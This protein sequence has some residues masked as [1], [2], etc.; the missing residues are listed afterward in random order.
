MCT[1]T[2]TLPV[3]H[4][5]FCDVQTYKVLLFYHYVDMTD[6]GRIAKWQNRLCQ[7]LNLKGK[8][9][10]ATEGIN[11]TAEGCVCST[12]LYMI[13]MLKYF[14]SMKKEDFKMSDGDGNSFDELKISECE[15]L[16][17]IGK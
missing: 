5:C 6:I 1:E 10:I 7:R 9:R 2:M 8:I 14:T 4:E 13:I 11:G 16:C 15:E 12:Q 3:V 17:S